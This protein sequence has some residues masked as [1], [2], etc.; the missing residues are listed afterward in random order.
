MESLENRTL[1]SVSPLHGISA[2]GHAATN[3][4]AIHDTVPAQFALD[5]KRAQAA[6]KTVAASGGNGTSGT[7][8]ITAQQAAKI[9]G[10]A[11]LIKSPVPDPGAPT[12]P[13]GTMEETD[14]PDGSY[15]KV[16]CTYDAN[17]HLTS[18]DTLNV[19]AD[20][21]ISSH[22]CDKWTYYADGNI[23]S[24]THYNYNPN[25][26]IANEEHYTYQENGSVGSHWWI[27]YTY[28][29]NG[30]L[31]GKDQV[32]YLNGIK[33]SEQVWTY[34]ANTAPVKYDCWYYNSTSGKL[35]SEEHYTYNSNGWCTNEE[36]YTYKA[37]GSVDSHYWVGYVYN[38]S[39]ST[40]CKDKVTYDANGV[41][42][43]EETWTYNADGSWKDTLWTFNANGT[44]KDR[45]VWNHNAAGTVVGRIHDEWTYNANGKKLTHDQ[46]AF[47]AQNV[48][49]FHGYRTFYANGRIATDTQSFQGYGMWWWYN[50]DGSVSKNGYWNNTGNAIVYIDGWS[51]DADGRD[52]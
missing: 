12:G 10:S 43:S 4:V 29:P 13:H 8:A 45:T 19:N 7:T 48:C 16:Q 39:G 52:S 37:N 25:G 3:A 35:S 23:A 31:A 2:V 20:G 18:K 41:K 42:T 38:A 21:S 9:I 5:W 30:S 47:N 46:W 51:K 14:Y 49:T 34:N 27:G 44:K 33:I 17:N 24:K 32:V 11:I 28:N 1:M 40:T 22:F 50:P 15:T 6:S 36:H 26:S